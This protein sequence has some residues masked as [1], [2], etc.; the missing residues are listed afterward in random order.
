MEIGPNPTLGS[1][2]AKSPFVAMTSI[3]AKE[4]FPFDAAVITT[5]SMY[6]IFTTLCPIGS[7][8]SDTKTTFTMSEE[9]TSLQ[10]IA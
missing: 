6:S 1:P 3:R 7:S 9:I 8:L 2:A 4:G 5:K 10:L